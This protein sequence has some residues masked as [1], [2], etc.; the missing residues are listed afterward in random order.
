MRRF[1]LVKLW[2]KLGLHS[3]HASKGVFCEPIAQFPS[4]CLLGRRGGDLPTTAVARRGVAH[5]DS[6]L[7]FWVAMF[8]HLGGRDREWVD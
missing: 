8:A 5:R 2:V 3:Y 4:L 6:R 7:G 1:A